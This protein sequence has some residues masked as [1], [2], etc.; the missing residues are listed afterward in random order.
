MRLSRIAALR[1]STTARSHV[2]SLHPNREKKASS[3]MN[4]LPL[5]NNNKSLGL[6]FNLF[7][8]S[9]MAFTEYSEVQHHLKQTIETLEN[10]IISSSNVE[11][12]MKV[13]YM[14]FRY[15]EGVMDENLWTEERMKLSLYFLREL[16]TH[17]LPIM[18]LVLA[19]PLSRTN[20][21]TM[22]YVEGIFETLHRVGCTNILLELPHPNIPSAVKEIHPS[23]RNS[24]LK[25]WQL[26]LQRNGGMCISSSQCK[27][28]SLAELFPWILQ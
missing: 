22:S 6:Q 21:M 10:V 26:L 15:S 14:V 16:T 28:L 5:H 17:I 20:K 2:S 11:E 7:P 3:H 19:L 18:P 9:S 1:G 23:Y 8:F 13:D 27:S 4:K 24:V 25:N 12:S